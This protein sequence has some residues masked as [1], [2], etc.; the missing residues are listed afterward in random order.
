MQPDVCP[1]SVDRWGQ[2][3]L[4]K[5]L[6]A[7]T[8]PAMAPRWKA[9]LFQNNRMG[10]WGREGSVPCVLTARTFCF[11]SQR[12]RPGVRVRHSCSRP[13][14]GTPASG[15]PCTGPCLQ[16]VFALQWLPTHTPLL[17]P[18]A[19]PPPGS[20]RVPSPPA[21]H[22]RDPAFTRTPARSPLPHF[23]RCP[24]PSLWDWRPP[25]CSTSGHCPVLTLLELLADL[26]AAVCTS[27]L[28]SRSAG[29][30]AP[31][32]PHLQS[33][34][35]TCVLCSLVLLEAFTTRLSP[36]PHSP[37]LSRVTSPPPGLA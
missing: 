25:P 5:A 21:F 33:S 32:T 17:R 29:P 22:H 20:G 36:F 2:P 6:A 14:A 4:W 26:S 1:F 34:R 8:P 28:P 18:G 37:L 30:L 31:E 23:P 10:C 19:A 27:T 24:P 12:P 3:S 15:S 9:L 7:Y 13:T 11:R 35:C 16:P